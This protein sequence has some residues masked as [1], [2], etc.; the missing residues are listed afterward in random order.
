MF[1]IDDKIKDVDDVICENIDLI[2]SVGRGLVSQNILAQTRNLLEYIAIKA[3]SMTHEIQ[4]NRET[5]E[6]ARIFLRSDYKFLFIRQF[7]S[8]IQESKSH[9]TPD[10][11]GAERLALKYYEYYVLL[12]N[13]VKQEYGLSILHNLEKYPLN[14]DMAV[15]GYYIQVAKSLQKSW[16]TMDFNSNRMY[17]MRSKPVYV[18][19]EIIYENTLIPAEQG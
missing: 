1:D 14:L 12:R 7:H 10:K 15:K 16:Q 3:Y 11:D 17:V 18:E 5:N 19:G 6:K 8:L 9:Y 2:E 13:F 4:Y